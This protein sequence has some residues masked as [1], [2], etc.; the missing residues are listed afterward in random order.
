MVKFTAIFE[1][2][3]KGLISIMAFIP[4]YVFLAFESGTVEAL[5]AGVIVAISIFAIL[6]S[7]ILSIDEVSPLTINTQTTHENPHSQP[8]RYLVRSIANMGIR[9]TLN[10]AV[11]F[12]CVIIAMIILAM[13]V[14]TFA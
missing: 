4:P 11:A 2:F 9:F 6:Y 12:A 7:N 8:L 13:I 5:I 3:L 14:S 1:P 10:A